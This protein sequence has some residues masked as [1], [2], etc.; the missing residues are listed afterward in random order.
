MNHQNLADSLGITL[1]P[2]MVDAINAVRTLDPG[3]YAVGIAASAEYDNPGSDPTT[4]LTVSLVAAKRSVDIVQH[5][6]DVQ[7][8]ILR[9]M[10]HGTGPTRTPDAFEYSHMRDGRIVT[11]VDVARVRDVVDF[12]YES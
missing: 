12:L 9:R 2:Q 6:D 10:G 11:Q 7:I 3:M 5:G 4:T 1:S 8:H